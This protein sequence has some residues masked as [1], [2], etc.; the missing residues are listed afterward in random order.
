MS[1]LLQ[2]HV[3]TFSEHALMSLNPINSRPETALGWQ[4]AQGGIAWLLERLH[5]FWGGCVTSKS[6]AEF[7]KA[8]Q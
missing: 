4:I 6:W 3:A 7:T 8:S 5:D 2:V 1:Q